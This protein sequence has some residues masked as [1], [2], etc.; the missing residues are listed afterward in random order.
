LKSALYA[1]FSILRAPCRGLKTTP[2]KQPQPQK[3]NY[4]NGVGEVAIFDVQLNAVSRSEGRS[5]TAAAYR[6]G[7]KI[8]DERT[9]E[10][11][12]YRR[13]NGVLGNH[14]VMPAGSAWNPTISELWNAAE[15][16]ENRKNSCVAK[17]WRIAFPAELT[18]ADNEALGLAMTNAIVERY[19]VGAML[20]IHAPSQEG[21]QRNL[22]AHLL[23]TDRKIEG[24]GLGAKNRVLA[25]KKTGPEETKWLREK[26]ATLV[27]AA[28]AQANRPERIDHRSR[29]ERG[30]DGPRMRHLGPAA[31][32]LERKGIATELGDQNREVAAYRAEI[33]QFPQMLPAKKK[34]LVDQEIEQTEAIIFDL[35]TERARLQA[36]AD[37]EARREKLAD[38]VELLNSL[39]FAIATAQKDLAGYTVTTAP[40]D[41]PGFKDWATGVRQLIS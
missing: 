1:K 15:Q 13:K 33:L 28:L 25:D 16:A 41:L 37:D 7:V 39:A 29:R 21:D 23:I 30:L 31:T 38:P 27:N 17:E 2:K 18:F 11:H 5:A 22:H 8:A 12:D 24:N 35:A 9:S 14:L 3:N 32:T 4:K 36:A 26:W 34:E 40:A 20:S 10:V 19:G 6:A